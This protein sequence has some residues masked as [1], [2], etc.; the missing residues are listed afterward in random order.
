[1][2]EKG[3]I[4]LPLYFIYFSFNFSARNLK[5]FDCILKNNYFFLNF[6]IR[7]LFLLKKENFENNYVNYTIKHF[8]MCK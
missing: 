2:Y 4:I 6:N 1:M 8:K 7:Y 5:C 3:K